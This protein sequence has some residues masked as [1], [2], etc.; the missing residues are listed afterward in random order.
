MKINLILNRFSRILYRK[1]K[2]CNFI[3]GLLLAVLLGFSDYIAGRTYFLDLYYLVPISFV[4]WFA[5]TFAG[6][7]IS[8]ICSMLWLIS[9][10]PVTLSLQVI[11]SGTSSLAFF[12]LISIL[13]VKLR[14]L[15]DHERFLSRTDHLTGAVNSRA[16]YEMATTEILHLSRSRG[17]FSV[18]Y[19]DL[20]NFKSVNDRF[21]HRTGDAVLQTVADTLMKSLRRTD[22]VARL[23]GDEFSILLPD[24]D[25]EA[26]RVV[27]SKVIENLQ[28][29][30]RQKSFNVTFSIGV[31]TCLSPPHN[32]DEI[33]TYVDN[34]MYDIKKNGKNSIKYDSFIEDK[35]VP[36]RLICCN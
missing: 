13:L 23:G 15:L 27:I 31:L 17:P 20:D 30:M 18:A 22:I 14:Q 19:I 21:G 29:R 33:I 34:L 9:T 32:L 35:C 8:V 5:G 3:T 28:A 16:F 25:C 36:E 1:G 26:A 11:W 7:T 24:T 12:V 2:T 6:I 10:H 4:A